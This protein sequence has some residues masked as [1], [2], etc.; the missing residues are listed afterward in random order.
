[1]AKPTV[2]GDLAEFTV[3][4]EPP[5]SAPAATVSAAQVIVKHPNGTVSAPVAM[6]VVT[7]NVWRYTAATRIDTRGTWTYRVNA[8]AGL[9]DSFEFSIEIARSLFPVPLP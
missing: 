4:F 8:N 3:T 2:V 7:P 6:T 9:I 1:M 5:A